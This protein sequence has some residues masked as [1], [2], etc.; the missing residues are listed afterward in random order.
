MGVSGELNPVFELVRNGEVV[1]VVRADGGVEVLRDGEAP[2]GYPSLRGA[3]TSEGLAALRLADQF[4]VDDVDLLDELLSVDLD[5]PDF[6]GTQ[7]EITVNDETVDIA[8]EDLGIEGEL[9]AGVDSIGPGDVG[10][11]LYRYGPWLQCWYSGDPDQSYGWRPERELDLHAE[12]LNFVCGAFADFGP[13]DN[14]DVTSDY[15][16]ENLAHLDGDTDPGVAR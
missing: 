15:L 3:I 12:A 7:F 2:V 16:T 5:N 4:R 6:P 13:W 1:A 9:I 10:R 11:W 14:L 8:L